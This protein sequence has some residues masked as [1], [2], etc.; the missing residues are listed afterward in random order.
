[1]ASHNERDSVFNEP[2]LRPQPARPDPSEQRAARA[3]QSEARRGEGPCAPGDSVFDEPDI[4]PGRPTEVVDRDWSCS[5]CGYNRRGLPNDHPCPECGHLELYR[6]SPIGAPGYATWLQGRTA[7]TSDSKSWLVAVSLMLLG[8]PWAVLAALFD[9]PDA[10]LTGGAIFAVGFFGPTLEEV[11]K[12][13][14]VAW[15]V[16][17][18]PYLFKRVEQLQAAAVG[19]A[20]VFAALENTLYLT[21]RFPNASTLLTLWR[22]TVCVAL[23]VG[24][25]LLASRGLVRTWTQTMQDLRPPRLSLARS[26]LIVAILL[27]GG[28]NLLALGLEAVLPF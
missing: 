12:V 19:S 4:L 15:V 21:V 27:H 23:H 16:E 2:H 13:A 3:L 11:M 28:Y 17:V 8:G 10:T 14:L 9:A 5:A 1:M 7:A 18:R 6:P 26:W 25:T 24:C 22:W 20:F